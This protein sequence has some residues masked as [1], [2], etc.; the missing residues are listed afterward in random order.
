MI[1]F[2][3][4]LCCNTKYSTAPIVIYHYI[5]G[6]CHEITTFSASVHFLNLFFA[7]LQNFLRFLTIVDSRIITV[8]LIMDQH[9]C[10]Q[11]SKAPAFAMTQYFPNFS[12]QEGQSI[13]VNNSLFKKSQKIQLKCL[14]LS[15]YRKMLSQSRNDSA[16]LYI[17]PKLQPIVDAFKS[18]YVNL[19]GIV[20][21]N[22]AYNRTKLLGRSVRTLNEFELLLYLSEFHSMLSG[23]CLIWNF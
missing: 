9:I 14:I 4:L 12:W 5:F 17:L 22:H 16:I 13:F 18:T 15:E 11:H 6:H 20:G 7:S 3:T 23:S 21:Q 1:R 19:N 8:W 10:A 2:Y